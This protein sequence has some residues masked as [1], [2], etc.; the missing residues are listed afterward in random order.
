MNILL[1]ALWAI[2]FT[3]IGVIVHE[4]GHLVCGLLSGYRFSMFRLGPLAWFKENGRIRFSV[5]Q[6]LFA[7]QCL[8]APVEEIKNFKFVL[9]N[10]GGSIFNFLLCVPFVL[11]GWQA[12]LTIILVNFTLGFLN[13]L[14]I[15][16]LT[17]D[18]ANIR[19]A[20]K[21][22]EATRGLYL[23][24]Y[25]NAKMME[26]MRY[27]DFDK[28]LFALPENADLENYMVA[29][30]LLQEASRLEDNKQIKEALNMY[31]RID[32]AAMPPIYKNLIMAEILYYHS[33]LIP[34]HDAARELCRDK[35]FQKFMKCGLPSITRILAAYA[36]F[37]KGDKKMAS[38]LLAK[39]KAG[40]GKLPGKGQRMMEHDFLNELEE[41]FTK[42]LTQTQDFAQ[43]KEEN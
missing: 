15:R 9:Y 36:F 20:L 7:G 34:S 1:A 8:M 13:L 32:L 26:G 43:T 38:D 3:V 24:F 28:D 23:M 41:S 33:F 21:S 22:K 10:A 2:L 42:E 40:A 39:A 5:T 31:S 14:P 27:R 35:K 25:T 4:L 16:Y 29:H 11:L 18:G 12:N 17:N 30:I 37:V 19:E 6:N